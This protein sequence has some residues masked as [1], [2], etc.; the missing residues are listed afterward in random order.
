VLADAAAEVRFRDDPYVA[1][2]RPRSVL[3]AP[4]RYMGE[5]SG[6]IYLENNLAPGAFTEDRIEVLELLSG[7]IGVSIANAELYGQ[8]EERVKLRTT[9]LEARNRFISQTFGRYLSDE[10]VEEL[11]TTGESAGLS[12]EKR[13]VTLIFSDLRGFT[14]LAEDLPPED[15]VSLINTYLGVM[16]E[17]LTAHK[18]TIIDFVGDAI[19]ALFGAPMSHADDAARAVACAIDMQAAMARV[20][21]LNAER[22]YP[23]IGMGIGVNTGDVILGSIGSE[24]RAKYT[25]LG[26]HVNLASRIES[27]TVA[28]DVI[29]SEATLADA[30]AVVEV[31]AQA[32]VQPKGV[33]TPIVISY[34]RGLGAP[35]DR[36][37]PDAATELVALTE[38]LAVRFAEVDGKSVGEAECD[39]WIVA[40][41]ETEAELRGAP[42]PDALTDLRLTFA[43]PGKARLHAFG[44]VLPGAVADDREGFRLAFTS[45]PARTK[46]RLRDVLASRKVLTGAS[47]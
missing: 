31:G 29:L 10:I 12:G 43:G 24:K 37:L 39:A 30:G 7:Q 5:V 35:Y 4:L 18:A 32:T 36:R 13:R 40:L 45:L 8:L 34:V 46:A 23:A 19:I 20:N 6:V 27:F 42:G 17:V 33:N 38:P 9:Q 15:V 26:Q 1:T 14:T 25:V 47:T 2:S 41:S 22:G 3:C 21:A 28:G 16:T 44:K 11:L